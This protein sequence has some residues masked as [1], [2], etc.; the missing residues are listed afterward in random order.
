LKEEKQ[1]SYSAKE[2]QRVQLEKVIDELTLFDDGTHIDVEVQRSAEGSHVRRSRFHSGVLDTRMLMRN[3]KFK[4]MRD[5]YVIFIC[6][7]DKFQKNL[8][9]YHVERY[10]EETGEPVNDGSHIIYVNGM[11]RGDD[12]VGQLMRDFS[13]RASKDIRYKELADGVRHFKETEKGRGAM[14]DAFEKLANERAK[15]AANEKARDSARKMLENGKLALEEI[16]AITDLPIETIEDL[17][18]LQTV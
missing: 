2:K 11:Y 13:C 14:C 5:S 12:E 10:V 16:A 3:E 18:G 6:E 1:K 15:E 8:P 9:M 7:H 4:H 17:A